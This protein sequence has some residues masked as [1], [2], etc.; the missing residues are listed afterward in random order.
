VIDLR[1]SRRHYLDHLLPIWRALPL[2]EQG[3]IYVA[4]ELGAMVPGAKDVRFASA[5]QGIPTL[6]A[7]FDDLRM[8]NLRPAILM[9]H[10][11]GQSYG[12]ETASGRNAGYPGGQSRG[13]GTL[14]ILSPNEQAAARDRA[15]VGDVPVVV[16]GSP[17]LAE[18]QG[19]PAAPPPGEKLTV[20]FSFHW[21]CQIAPETIGGWPHWGE[22][23]RDLARTGEFEVLCHA[24]P[25]TFKNLLP[26]MREW[27]LTPVEHFDDLLGRAHVYCCDN[28][29]TLFEWAALRGPTVVLDNP[30]YRQDVNHG[31][32][33]WDCA[34]V[35][36][37]I[38]DQAALRLAILSAWRTQPWPG[39]DEIIER[40]FPSIPDPAATAAGVILDVAKARVATKRRAGLWP[41]QAP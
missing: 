24:H 33:F 18:L 37:R 8:C 10:G 9:E 26:L 23:V 19:V 17:R 21:N 29:S 31:L 4:P 14:V 36:P 15:V 16:V 6:V 2:E 34:G 30:W 1:A 11:A 7:S 13:H 20:A 3:T 28:S 12:G 32:R 40:V 27:G 35:G 41:R 39:A 25:R 5:E 22:A 38:L